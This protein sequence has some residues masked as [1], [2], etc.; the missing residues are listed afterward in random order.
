MFF[1]TFQKWQGTLIWYG[2]KNRKYVSR[3]LRGNQK[4]TVPQRYLEGSFLAMFAL[5]QAHALDWKSKLQHPSLV[6]STLNFLR[7]QTLVWKSII[8]YISHKVSPW[9]YRWFATFYPTVLT[10]GLRNLQ[11][12]V[13]FVVIVHIPK[14]SC[15]IW[16]FKIEVIIS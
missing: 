7:F 16:M 13:R 3:Y 5:L 2:R 10:A 1:S 9:M 12:Q 15:T 14:N 11:S 8:V 4:E 6:V